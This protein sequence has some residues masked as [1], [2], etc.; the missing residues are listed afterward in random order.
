M[1]NLKCDLGCL[2][3]LFLSI[4]RDYSHSFVY[5][6]SLV[7]DNIRSHTKTLIDLILC[8]FAT[9]IDYQKKTERM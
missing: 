8:L 9:A 2:K 7:M 1:R 5:V 4:R 6:I 3:S